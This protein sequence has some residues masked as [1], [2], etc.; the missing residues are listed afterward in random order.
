M[1]KWNNKLN[2]RT[3]LE[4]LVDEQEK[5]GLDLWTSFITY[6]LLRKAYPMIPTF[7]FDL[8]EADHEFREVF[9]EEVADEL[10]K[11]IEEGRLTKEVVYLMK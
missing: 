9:S 6:W 10:V 3:D 8:I 7:W 5:L 11:L 4:T 1:K 2:I